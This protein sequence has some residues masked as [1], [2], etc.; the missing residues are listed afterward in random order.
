MTLPVKYCRVEA[1]YKLP[2]RGIT[3]H[4]TCESAPPA[5]RE[6]WVQELDRILSAHVNDPDSWYL[7]YLVLM[8]P[9]SCF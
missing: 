4:L 2:H 5:T 6:D 1:S 3:F 7:S 9:D 8:D